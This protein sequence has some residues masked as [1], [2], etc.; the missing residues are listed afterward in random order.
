MHHHQGGRSLQEFLH[1]LNIELVYI[2]AYSPD[3]NPAGYVFGK[4]K[5]LLKNQLWELKRI[6][7]HSSK[8][9]HPWRHAWIL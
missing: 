5:C 3:F 8:F 9:Y 1:N 6:L 2:P 4:L 7:V